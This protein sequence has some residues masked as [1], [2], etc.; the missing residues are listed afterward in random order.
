MW[1]IRKKTME[2]TCK[3]FLDAQDIDPLGKESQ[4][5]LATTNV[6]SGKWRLWNERAGTAGQSLIGFPLPKRVG[7]APTVGPMQGARPS[8]AREDA[9]RALHDCGISRDCVRIRKWRQEVVEAEEEEDCIGVGSRPPPP[10]SKGG[11]EGFNVEGGGSRLRGG[12][13]GIGD[14]APGGRGGEGSKGRGGF[15]Q[16]VPFRSLPSS[17]AP[18]PPLSTLKQPPSPLPKLLEAPFEA[19]LLPLPR[20]LPLSGPPSGGPPSAGPPKISLFFLS[21]G[22]F[23]LNFGGV[24]EDRGPQISTFGLSVGAAGLHTTA[25]ELQTRTFEGPALRNTTKFPRKDTQE[26]GERMNICGGRRKKRENLGS[27]PFGAPLFFWVLCRTPLFLVLGK[28]G[29]TL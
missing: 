10:P 19:P 8:A 6:G 2:I 29:A 15:T 18:S 28:L 24:C 25:T 11:G 5:D 21:L 4:I 22:V 3:H 23:S 7:Q 9:F 27:P 13:G 12:E 16:H 1:L 20:S 26:R 14:V 17:E